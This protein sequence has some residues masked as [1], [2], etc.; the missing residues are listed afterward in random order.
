MYEKIA[1]EIDKVAEI[2]E[3]KGLT[4]EA[5]DLDIIA[6]TLEKLAF[7]ITKTPVYKQISQALK[8]IKQGNNPSGI[9]TNLKGNIIAGLFSVEKKT[10]PAIKAFIVLLDKSIESLDKNDGVSTKKHLEEALVQ[11]TQSSRGT[12][13]GYERPSPGK[14][15]FQD[16]SERAKENKLDK[17]EVPNY[18]RNYKPASSE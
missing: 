18:L 10:D 2:L 8:F 16:L 11:Y 5:M 13:R 15:P 12:G 6:N 14:K 17:H 7:D 3:K 1:Q 9:L 4:K